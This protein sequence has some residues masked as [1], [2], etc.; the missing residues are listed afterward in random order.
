MGVKQTLS[1]VEGERAVA[2]AKVR[3][4]GAKGEC[5]RRKFPQSHLLGK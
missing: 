1:V 3:E 4:K 5:M 2:V